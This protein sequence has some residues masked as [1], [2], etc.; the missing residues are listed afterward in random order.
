ML[1]RRVSGNLRSRASAG[2]EPN[3]SHDIKPASLGEPEKD[4]L[5][6]EGRGAPLS[7]QEDAWPGQ[8][9]VT[10]GEGDRGID[11]DLLCWRVEDSNVREGRAVMV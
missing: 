3:S 7:W 4:A 2:L 10:G 1:L 9:V 11:M 6:L 8:A 5:Q